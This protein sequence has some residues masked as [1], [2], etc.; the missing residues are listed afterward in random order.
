MDNKKLAGFKHRRCA[1]ASDPSLLP[2]RKERFP[3]PSRGG[4]PN[5]AEGVRVVQL[6]DEEGGGVDSVDAAEVL[7]L[8]MI[9]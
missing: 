2:D 6:K 8:V 9:I 3:A 4:G 5:D 7:I 1:D